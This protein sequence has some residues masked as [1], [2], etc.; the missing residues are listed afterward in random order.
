MYWCDVRYRMEFADPKGR[1]WKRVSANQAFAAK[2]DSDDSTRQV[3]YG[4]RQDPAEQQRDVSD[5]ELVWIHRHIHKWN[6]QDW[7][8][9]TLNSEYMLTEAQPLRD[10]VWHGERP[11]VMGRA[12]IETHKPMPE[13]IPNLVKGLQDEAN[14]IANQR[15]DNVKFVLN[16]AYLVKRG[17]N[18]DIPSLIRNVPGRI[19]LCDDPEKDVQ[20]MTW[21]DVTQSSYL[22]QDRIDGDF[23]DVVGNFS[24]MQVQTQRTP[25]ESTHT[26]K[27]LQAPSNMMTEYLLKTLTETFAQ[28]VLRQLM[29]LE[30]KYETD[31][32]LLALAGQKAKI[33]QRY[34]MSE[35]TDEM[36][37]RHLTLTVNVGMGATDPVMK[38]QRF[39]YGITSYQNI[40]KLP[41]P[42]IDLKA[43]WKEI[44]GL[45]GYQDGQRFLVDGVDPQVAKLMQTNQ[46]LMKMMQMLQMQVKNKEGAN[47]ARIQ[48]GKDANE[49]RERI[50]N[51]NNI[52]KLLTER[53]KQQGGSSLL[54]HQIAMDQHRMDIEMHGFDQQARQQE[55]QHEQQMHAMEMAQN[56][57]QMQHSQMENEMDLDF[58]RQQQEMTLNHQSENQAM[59]LSHADQSHQ[60]KLKM[61]AQ[62]PK[63]KT[64]K[65]KSK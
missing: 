1:R 25:R 44:A 57:S 29:M 24:P 22:E 10:S 33:A 43:V 16:K 19:T 61:A 21:Q 27:M 65:K 48:A 53:M 6:G 56:F 8:F 37:D 9:Y 12:I 13:S 4:Y 5:Y 42:G 26:M 59:K 40:T 49:T 50:A 32:V 38:L 52:T 35:V 39:I 55:M 31:S 20:E 36:L 47:Q 7:E 2:Q 11:Y 28:P 14:E 30:Q 17:K 34:G 64:A 18:V 46:Q 41:P 15:M 23:N 62:K 58:Q 45:S 60:Q 54:D 3:R 63:K 51:H